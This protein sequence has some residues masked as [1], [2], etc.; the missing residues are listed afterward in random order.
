MGAVSALVWSNTMKHFPWFLL[1]L[2]S[3]AILVFLYARLSK[4]QKRT[5]R[6][7][8]GQIRYLP[9]RYSV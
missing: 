4:S 6:H 8:M 1:G 5:I 7:L 2:L 9:A 3:A